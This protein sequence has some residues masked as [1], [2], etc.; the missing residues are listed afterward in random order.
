VTALLQNLLNGLAIGSIYAL[1]ALGYTLIFSILRIINFAH[2]AVFTVG[3]YLTYA[4]MGKP[5]G[6]GDYVFSNA[7]LPF[8]LNF[9]LAM[10][11]AAVLSGLLNI[12]LERLAFRPLRE[13]GS[14]TLLTLVSSLGVSIMLS[15]LIQNL[16]G[17]DPLPAPEPIKNLKPAV[18]I[19]GATIQSVR[20]IVF[21][22]AVT[23]MIGLWYLLNRTRTG[24]AL[25][26]ISEDA[27]TSNL[28]GISTDRLI[29]VTFGLCGFVAA[30]AGTMVSVTVGITG[31]YMG[32]NFGLIGLAVII[33]GGLG[34][35]P[36]AVLAGFLVG[37]AQ[38]L[39]SAYKVPLLSTVFP[40]AAK[41][42][43]PFILLFLVLMFRPQGLL[44]RATVQKV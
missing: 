39:V 7:K 5:F 37:I 14:D 34:D 42:A 6:G 27:T 20:I 12:A 31:P 43:I 44:G 33:L 2:G 38:T 19:G 3:A 16:V 29:M 18:T 21:V 24:K 26:A 13:R 10:F 22:V 28:L 15:N 25:K 23:V 41:D 17:A 32:A 4:L 11:I 30:I 8:R 9:W 1:F 35:I 40:T 36:G